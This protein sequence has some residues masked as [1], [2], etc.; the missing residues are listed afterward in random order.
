MEDIARFYSGIIEG[1]KAALGAIGQTCDSDRP[2]SLSADAIDGTNDNSRKV[3]SKSD[4]APQFRR[5]LQ[6]EQEKT[7]GMN[8]VFDQMMNGATE[9]DMMSFVAEVC[10][11]IE[12]LAGKC[13]S[14]NGF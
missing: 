3:E 11:N 12:I 9:T 5:G 6:G 1:P 2:R 8:T 4:I 13:M 7:G 10:A 14:T